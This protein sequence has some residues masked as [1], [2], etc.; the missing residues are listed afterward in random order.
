MNHMVA[1]IMQRVKTL[2]VSRFEVET[3]SRVDLYVKSLDRVYRK[4]NAC[5]KLFPS[6]K[7]DSESTAIV[8]DAAHHQIQLCRLSITNVV[9]SVLVEVI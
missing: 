9:K 4:I 2:L 7:F 6:L 8:L 3:S 5:C 1:E